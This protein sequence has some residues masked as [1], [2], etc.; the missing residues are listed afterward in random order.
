MK[1][2]V[3]G[4]SGYIGSVL[5]PM[6]QKEGHE[7]IGLDSDIYRRCTFSG[8]LPEFPVMRKDVRDVIQDELEGFD[9]IIH[10]AGLSNDPLGDYRPELTE[11]MKPVPPLRRSNSF[12]VNPQCFAGTRSISFRMW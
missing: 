2:L 8:V 5:V 10:L 12:S 7:V 1:V 9:A 11:E 4:C 6:L 3:T